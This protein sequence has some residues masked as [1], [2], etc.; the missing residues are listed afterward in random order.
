MPTSTLS[1]IHTTPQAP[2]HIP[3]RTKLCAFLMASHH[4]EA[5]H[6]LSPSNEAGIYDPAYPWVVE[7]TLLNLLREELLTEN[8][9]QMNI[10]DLRAL[11]YAAT[12]EASPPPEPATLLGLVPEFEATAHEL[13]TGQAFEELARELTP[14]RREQFRQDLR[15]LPQIIRHAI[16]N[17]PCY[18]A[19][20]SGAYAIEFFYHRAWDQLLQAMHEAGFHWEDLGDIRKPSHDRAAFERCLERQDQLN[21]WRGVRNYIYYFRAFKR[22]CEVSHVG[23]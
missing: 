5:C 7:G 6:H 11:L 23:N 8:R 16:Q 10:Q 1:A 4:E 20:E 3:T 13:A 15:V 22:W 9:H 2:E 12:W 17:R 21:R 19:A 18:D 14:A